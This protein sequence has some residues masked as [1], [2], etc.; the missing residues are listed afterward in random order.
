M[1]NLVPLWFKFTLKTRCLGLL[2]SEADAG[3]KFQ[4]LEVA[5]RTGH[6]KMLRQVYLNDEGRHYAVE[7]NR[8]NGIVGS[9]THPKAIVKEH[10]FHTGDALV[11]VSHKY[12]FVSTL[13]AGSRKVLVLEFWN[14]AECHCGHRCDDI[15]G[16]CTFIDED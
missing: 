2:L 4:T 10:S 12:H 8:Y 3:A 7:P 16:N 6:R 9:L 5:N 14:G 15:S 13:S 1:H 11:F